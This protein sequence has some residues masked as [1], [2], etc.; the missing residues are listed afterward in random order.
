MSKTKVEADLQPVSQAES[1]NVASAPVAEASGL[2]EIASPP[3]LPASGPEISE[4]PKEPQKPRS[5]KARLLVDLTV[6]GVLYRSGELLE[7]DADV[8]AAL[9]DQADTH[10][11]AVA[12]C[13][14]N[15]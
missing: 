14:A 11:D 7:A 9:G 8:I 13:E 5:T 2:G 1:A 4:S 10:P 12:Y 6:A 3:V 15:Q